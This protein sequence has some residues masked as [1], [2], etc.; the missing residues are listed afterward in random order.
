MLR[1]NYADFMESKLNMA[2]PSALSVFQ[3]FGSSTNYSG[4]DRSEWQQ[5]TL[6]SHHLHIQLSKAATTRNER[7]KIQQESWC[8]L[9]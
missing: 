1:E 7:D 5:R 4:F 9:F 3:A 6:T 2:V 8:T